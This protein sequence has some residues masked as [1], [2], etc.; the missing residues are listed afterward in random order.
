[1]T[2]KEPSPYFKKYGSNAVRK[3]QP[4]I[5]LIRRV[6]FYFVGEFALAA[7]SLRSKKMALT[8]VPPHYLPS[9]CDLEA[10]GR[11]AMSL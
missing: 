6:Y 10:F 9:G 4:N 11:A 5:P 8:G 1:V 7:R 3:R 2:Q